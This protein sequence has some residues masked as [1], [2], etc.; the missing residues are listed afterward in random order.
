M[1]SA[2]STLDGP[3][4]CAA[5][6]RGTPVACVAARLHGMG[7]PRSRWPELARLAPVTLASRERGS[8]APASVRGPRV[9]GRRVQAAGEGDGDGKALFGTASAT[10]KLQTRK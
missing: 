2:R 5:R 3:A 8:V 6:R 9:L 1:L 4:D 7:A 10:L